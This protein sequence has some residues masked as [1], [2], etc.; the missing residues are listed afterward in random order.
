MSYRVY[1]DNLKN[2]THDINLIRAGDSY[3]DLVTC[4][5]VSPGVKPKHPLINFF[6]NKNICIATDIELMAGLLSCPKIAVTGTNGKSTITTWL[7]AALCQSEKWYAVGNI[8]KPALSI[9][10]AQPDGVVIELSSAQLHYINTLDLEIS[11]CAAI[12][13]DHLDWH[14]TLAEYQDSKLK[15]LNWGTAIR[16]SSIA[17]HGLS[18][19]KDGDVYCEGNYIYL[20][21]AMKI[22][23]DS[24]HYWRDV[25]QENLAAVAAALY[26]KNIIWS[27]MPNYQHLA[28]RATR[29]YHKDWIM[30]N[31]SKATNLHATNNTLKDIKKYYKDMPIIL[32]IG[33]VLKEEFIMPELDVNDRLCVFG[34]ARTL[35]PASITTLVFSTLA[36]ALQYLQE[37]LVEYDPG[38]ILLAP[39]GASWDEFDGYAQRGLFFESWVQ[40]LC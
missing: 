15:I 34:Q 9:L 30:I 3:L 36:Q 22:K 18:Y 27:E 29:S 14:E 28:H 7:T 31:D 21:N 32:L 2:I 5:W 25:D 17:A 13:A 12:A 19:G 40:Q 6:K 11:I 26:V 16:H 39:G 24:K 23:F 33:G 35:V 37:H 10:P 4:V 38:I 8:G 1:D 20:P